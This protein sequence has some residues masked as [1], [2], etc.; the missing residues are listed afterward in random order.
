MAPQEAQF[1]R[2]CKGCWTGGISS[3]FKKQKME[4]IENIMIAKLIH[5]LVSH[6]K[7]IDLLLGLWDNYTSYI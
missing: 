6:V 5:N 2:V 4:Y 3:G 1:G 7:V